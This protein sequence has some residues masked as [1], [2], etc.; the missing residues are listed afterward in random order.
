MY[1]HSQVT[2]YKCSD[3]VIQVWEDKM[4]E[5]LTIFGKIFEMYY[6]RFVLQSLFHNVKRNIIDIH[7]KMNAYLSP[8]E[9]IGQNSQETQI[10]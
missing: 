8:K 6:P 10:K 1:E 4:V 9:I 3:W 2:N 5:I 7:E